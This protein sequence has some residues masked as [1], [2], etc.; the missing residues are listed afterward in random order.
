MKILIWPKAHTPLEAILD[1]AI[2]FVTHGLGTHV[3]FL[4]ADGKT[5][6]EA[7]FPKVRDR[8]L[9]DEDRAEIEVYSLKGMTPELHAAFEARFDKNLQLHIEYSIEDLFRYE[10]NIPPDDKHTYCSRYAFHTCELVV[11]ADMLPQAVSRI[12]AGEAISPRDIRISNLLIPD[13][14]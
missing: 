14:L 10:L 8:A 2:A 12:Q 3:A 4:R 6:H 5:V 1:D 9:T 11:P 13:S 7:F